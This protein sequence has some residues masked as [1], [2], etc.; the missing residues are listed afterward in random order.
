VRSK[1]LKRSLRA[2][3]Q[4]IVGDIEC[5]PLLKPFQ[6]HKGIKMINE[7]DIKAFRDELKEAIT[8]EPIQPGEHIMDFLISKTASLLAQK[9][10]KAWYW[11]AANLIR[12]TAGIPISVVSD[13][14]LNMKLHPEDDPE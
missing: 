8:S 13:M 9:C 1:A 5:C 2:H 4:S 12:Q 11:D 14:Q 10:D 7:H 3:W 6:Y